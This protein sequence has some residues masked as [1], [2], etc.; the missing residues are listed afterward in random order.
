MAN[1]PG[2]EFLQQISLQDQNQVDPQ[3]P[4]FT[5]DDRQKINELLAS[6]RQ[7]FKRGQD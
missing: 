2:Q 4:P 6:F 7:L 3:M 1:H 5:K